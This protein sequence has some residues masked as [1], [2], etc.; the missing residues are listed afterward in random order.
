M[1]HDCE[2]FTGPRWATIQDP[3]ITP[4]GR[5]LRRIHVDELPQLWNVLRGE[6]SLVGPRPERP[7]IAAHLEQMLPGYHKRL[8]LRPGLTGLAQVQL[9]A[10]QDLGSVRTKLAHDL[11]Y[12]SN[13]GLSLD[14]RILV[15]TAWQLLGIPFSVSNRL[16]QL[17]VRE[18][19]EQAYQRTLG[20][21]GRIDVK[22]QTT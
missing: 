16:L 3:R 20:G 11:Y 21:N 1:F 8:V 10:D 14:V 18:H 9:P 15:C 2:R 12:V 22:M 17:P 6:M 4:V 19:V 5:W 13:L 7:E